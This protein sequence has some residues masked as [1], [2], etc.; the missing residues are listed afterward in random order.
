M[1]DFDTTLIIIADQLKGEATTVKEIEEFFTSLDPVHQIITEA[2]SNAEEPIDAWNAI[3]EE[4]RRLMA[5]QKVLSA[6]DNVNKTT[7]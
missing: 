5:A 3:E 4:I 6:R 7:E 1:L 2:I